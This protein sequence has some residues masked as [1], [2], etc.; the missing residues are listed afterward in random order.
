V[1]A[2]KHPWRRVF[3]VLPIMLALGALTW[4]QCETWRDPRT[5]WMRVVAL[6]PDHAYGHKILGDV[7]QTA[8]DLD[9]AVVE[10]RRAVALRP[11]PEAYVPLAAAL[12]AQR[13]SDEAFVEYRNAVRIR[14]PTSGQRF[15]ASC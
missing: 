15:S 1:A 8:G 9:T 3:A 5:M 10:Y 7:A 2:A 6:A 12:A 13:R 11:L 4:R 14:P